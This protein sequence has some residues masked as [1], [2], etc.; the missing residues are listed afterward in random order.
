[1]YYVF[2]PIKFL[3]TKRL[4]L[5]LLRTIF[6]IIDHKDVI[7][8]KL[9]YFYKYKSISLYYHALVQYM[10]ILFHG[11]SQDFT[12]GTAYL[13]LNTQYIFRIFRIYLILN[14]SIYMAY[15]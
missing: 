13:I 6:I 14:L 12:L 4:S 11:W 1:M 8:T 7:S 3:L 15:F 9:Y 5:S 2:S 10:S